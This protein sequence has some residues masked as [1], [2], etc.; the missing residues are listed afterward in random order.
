MEIV[1]GTGVFCKPVRF[2]TT[3]DV[4][5]QRPTRLCLVLCYILWQHVSLFYWK[6]IFC[7]SEAKFTFSGIYSTLMKLA[8][9]KVCNS[10]ISEEQFPV[11][12]AELCAN[13]GAM[14][15]AIGPITLDASFSYVLA[16]FWC[17][18]H[19]VPGFGAY[20]QIL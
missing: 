6:S 7:V 16:S 17:F 11:R 18:Q 13:I 10:T 2:S 1:S 5:K 20:F 8:R 19:I 3:Q 15:L 4:R 9:A 14:Q 12:G